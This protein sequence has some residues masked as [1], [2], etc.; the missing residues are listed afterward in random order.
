[1]TRIADLPFISLLFGPK[2]YPTREEEVRLQDPYFLI[3]LYANN[4]RILRRCAA[5]YHNVPYDSPRFRRLNLTESS[6]L[7]EPIRKMLLTFA[8]AMKEERLSGN[9]EEF[10]A[11]AREGQ[12]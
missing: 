12:L 3:K 5:T 6:V 9:A 7:V 10:E 8:E 1:M 11:T 2:D 4:P